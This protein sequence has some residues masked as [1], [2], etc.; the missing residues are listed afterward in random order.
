V[1]RPAFLLLYFG[2]V[3]FSLKNIDAK[4]ARKNVGEID[5]RATA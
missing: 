4:V 3:I 2:L 5:N 1:L